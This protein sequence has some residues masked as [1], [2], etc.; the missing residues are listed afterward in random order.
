MA[1]PMTLRRY[2]PIT[3]MSVTHAVDDLYQGAVPAL[4][5]FL[6]AERHY[7]YAAASGIT[8][9][10]TLLSSVAQPAFGMLTDRRQL[11]WLVPAGVTL[12]G[13]G[14]GLAG[15]SASYALTWLVIAASGLGVAAYHPAASRDARLA[16]GGSARGMSWFALGGNIGFALGPL[17]ATPILVAGGTAATPVLALPGVLTGIALVLRSRSRTAATRVTAPAGPPQ[18]DDWRSFRRLTAM[19]IC[20]S[21]CF[22]SLSSFL[23]LYVTH[24]LGATTVDG[25]TALTVFFVTGTLGTLL[26]GWLADRHGRVPAVRV[27]YALALPG[28]AG[29]LLAQ[30]TFLAYI[31]VAVLG[32]AL[33]V[34]FSVHV[35]LGQEYLPNRIGTAS[36]VT[37]GLAVSVGGL[38]APILGTLA[39]HIGLRPTLAILLAL[40]IAALVVSVRLPEG[41][42]V[43]SRP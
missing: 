9:A 38:A 13:L 23:A 19:V 27:G 42:T 3:G 2:A 29:L 11:G 20:R 37:L 28:L 17:V 10:A 40:P 18:D 24:T 21:I 39:D 35:T 32:L 1:L 7:S 12:A 43:G 33:Y 4:I 6:V 5:P 14:V 15:L 25:N 8:L 31:A 16:A 30:S 22:F 41:R 36:G 34:P 26:G